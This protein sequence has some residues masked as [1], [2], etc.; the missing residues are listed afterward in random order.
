RKEG[1]VPP[2]SDNVKVNFDVVFNLVTKN[3][4]SGVIIKNFEGL[5]MAACIYL[6][7]GVADAYVTE[8][9]MCEQAINF[10]MEL[11]KANVVVHALAVEGR[12]SHGPRYW[13]EEALQL[14]GWESLI[15]FLTP[16]DSQSF[17]LLSV[18]LEYVGDVV[19]RWCRRKGIYGFSSELREEEEA[20]LKVPFPWAAPMVP[21]PWAAPL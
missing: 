5:I 21:F 14:W 16:S 8:A 7:S 15:I 2:H 18:L 11:G 12:R 1:W 9:R 17:A 6:H 4:V 20:A 19:L 13:V 10:A 3:S